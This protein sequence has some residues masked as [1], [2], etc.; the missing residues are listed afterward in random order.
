MG[1]QLI[2]GRA[3][4]SSWSILYSESTRRRPVRPATEPGALR[5]SYSLSASAS[6]RED[7]LFLSPTFWF[8]TRKCFATKELTFA[9]LSL[10]LMILLF[11]HHSLCS[12][13]EFEISDSTN[14]FCIYLPWGLCVSTS[15]SSN[16][17]P[18]SSP[19]QQ[20]HLQS[21]LFLSGLQEDRNGGHSNEQ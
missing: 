21:A 19:T 20:D 10:W 8:G 18:G 15:A 13:D 1:I 3:R 4:K 6:L 14:W 11:L 7:S 17:A 16:Q 12:M 2:G 9:L 5:G